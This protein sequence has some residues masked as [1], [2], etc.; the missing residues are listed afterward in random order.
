MAVTRVPK[1]SDRSARDVTNYP[2]LHASDIEDA[3]F[4][5]HKNPDDPGG[6]GASVFTDLTDVPS[7]YTGLGGRYLKVKTTED[8]IETDTPAGSGD[9]TK[10]EYDA[11]NDGIVD[12]ADI[13]NS[14]NTANT[15]NTAASADIASDLDIDA[16]T[17]E[18]APTSGDMFVMKRSGVAYKV[19][20]DNLPGGGAGGITIDQADPYGIHHRLSGSHADDDE[21]SSNTLANYTATTPTGTASWNIGNHNL[22]CQ[23][24]GNSGSDLCTF[25][26]PITIADG[27]WIETSLK[28]LTQSA[29]YSFVG[30]CFTNGVLT[31]SSI[32]SAC[33]FISGAL[34]GRID[35]RY[36]T[37]TIT[38][39]SSAS[40]DTLFD[41]AITG[42]LRLRFKRVNSTTYKY[43]VANED[44]GFFYDWGAGSVN[45]GFTP[46]HAGLC[47]S[48]WG[49]AHKG[50]ASFDYFRHMS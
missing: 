18:T 8:G 33:F 32:A 12:A 13:A 10:A 20:A 23:F 3:T 39:L 27:E 31:T 15:A 21:F 41:L 26:K 42:S 35:L 6:G 34:P 19:N 22:I 7:S 44:G 24:N 4:L 29:N 48:T 9:M 43:Y 40:S 47:V 30:L 36:D 1:K 25:L 45:P 38:N 16:L 17:E 14:A 37:G 49:G 2:N 5:Y 11:N 46:T 50:L 28:M